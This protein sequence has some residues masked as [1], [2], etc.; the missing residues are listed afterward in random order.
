MQSKLNKCSITYVQKNLFINCGSYL[1]EKMEIQETQK[2]IERD[3][4]NE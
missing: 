3:N 1:L 2:Q 4:E